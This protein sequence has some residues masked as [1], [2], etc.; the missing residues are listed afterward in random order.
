MDRGFKFVETGECFRNVI[1]NEVVGL[2]RMSD[3]MDGLSGIA[4]DLKKS[5]I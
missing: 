2:L 4:L 3:G 1:K 5:I